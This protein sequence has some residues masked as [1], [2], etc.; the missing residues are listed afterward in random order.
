MREASRHTT[1]ENHQITKEESKST[2]SISSTFLPPLH[3][4]GDQLQTRTGK[5]KNVWK[6]KN[7]HLNKHWVNEEI[8]RD[9][10]RGGGEGGGVMRQ[11]QIKRQH[12]KT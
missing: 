6:F 9:G 2:V 5:L 12:T 8:K 3:D 11:I 10:A 7:L 4:T 1:T